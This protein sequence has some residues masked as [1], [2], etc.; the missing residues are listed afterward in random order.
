MYLG[1]E[2]T[3]ALSAWSSVLV[4]RLHRLELLHL[5]PQSFLKE[6]PPQSTKPPANLVG[7]LQFVGRKARGNLS[8]P[9]GERKLKQR[10]AVLIGLEVPGR[11]DPLG[12]GPDRF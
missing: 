8:R 5:P 11:G 3:S 4:L 12:G 1:R 9:V 6:I 7:R 10:A 2:C